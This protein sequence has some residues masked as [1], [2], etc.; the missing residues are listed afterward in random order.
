M[1]E[2]ANVTLREVTSY[3]KII[4]KVS[5]FKNQGVQTNIEKVMKAYDKCVKRGK[6]DL[7]K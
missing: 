7:M 6:N 5:L 4:Y 1:K 3:G 2:S